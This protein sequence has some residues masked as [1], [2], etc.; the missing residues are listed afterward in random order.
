MR[1]IVRRAGGALRLGVSTAW[2]GAVL[3]LVSVGL[4]GVTH[5][6]TTAPNFTLR[7]ID[8]NTFNLTDFRGR[9]DL[10]RRLGGRATVPRR[11]D[12][13]DHLRQ[14]RDVAGRGVDPEDE[15]RRDDRGRDPGDRPG[16][17]PTTG[18]HLRPRRDRGSCV[19]LLPVLV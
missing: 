1:G 4:S 19:L 9:S 17:R 8:G 15:P 6:D 16:D 3:V 2:A 10:L 7:D 18:Q 11:S 13:E 14:D 12:R 5:A